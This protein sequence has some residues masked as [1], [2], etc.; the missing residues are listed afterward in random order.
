M[1]EGVRPSERRR[2]VRTQ[3]EPGAACLVKVGK[4]KLPAVVREAVG[5]GYRVAMGRNP[6]ESDRG[7]YVGPSKVWPAA[8]PRKAIAQ[9]RQVKAPVAARVSVDTAD[10][11]PHWRGSCVVAL[12]PQPKDEPP[13][14][15]RAFMDY[16]KGLPC[17]GCGASPPNDPHHHGK[18]GLSVK[19]RD[20]LCIP[21]CRTCH[22]SYTDTYKLPGM[23]R[24]ATAQ[25][26]L[27][28][29]RMVLLSALAQLPSELQVEVLSVVIGR[30]SE[31]TILKYLKGN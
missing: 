24:A 10:G 31:E 22:D 14:R 3:L 17:V 16:V 21:L 11:L 8:S 23:T 25:R 18:H 9:R 5:K 13:A 30:L 15:T 4:L 6:P 27:D 19:V 26:L 29:Q 2:A 12:V 1:G 28:A 7:K 20:T